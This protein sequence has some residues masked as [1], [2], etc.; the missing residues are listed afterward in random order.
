MN[1][2]LCALRAELF[3][4]VRTTP[5]RLIVLM[6]ALIV[7]LR[8]ALEKITEAG[9]SARQSLLGQGSLDIAAGNAYGHFVDGLGT[10]LILLG[11]SLVSY[12]A[13]SFA[14][15]RDTGALRHLLIRRLS[16]RT[17]ILSKL[18]VAHLIGLV[19][20]LLML[21]VLFLLCSW[22]WEFGPV[23]EDG[24]ELISVAEMQK[25]V[26]LGFRLAVIPLPAAIA[27]GLLVAV[28]TQSATQAVSAALGITLA[29]DIFKGLLGDYSH[30]LYARFQPSLID[31]SYLQDV[32]RLVRGYSDVLID[33]RALLLNYWVPLPQ[34]LLFTAIA[35]L[36]VPARRL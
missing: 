22:L 29:L 3:V 20:L 26:S 27:F 23:V 21:L 6:P 33:E 18:L 4:A 9:N 1:N 11:L 10:G 2:F 30:Y 19:A 7:T 32:G 14:S 12:T 35:L 5:A 17:L 34:M 24:Y 8:L 16:R 13:W 36:V 28:L 15:D 25:E 31:A